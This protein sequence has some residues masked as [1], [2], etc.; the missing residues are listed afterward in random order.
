MLDAL[1]KPIAVLLLQLGSPDDAGVTAVRR[2]LR[3]FLSDPRVI[4]LPRW[5]WY[6]ILYGIVLQRRPAQSAA[7]YQLIWDKEKGFPLKYYTQR[8]AEELQKRLGD[9]FL[10]RYAMRYG[11]P[12][13]APVVAE[14]CAQ[15]VEKLI[16][17]PLYPQY[18]ATTTASALD[19]L[20]QILMRQRAVPAL[21]VVPPFYQHPAYVS[22]ECQVIRETLATLPQ[23]PEK[24]IFSFH[25]IP[26]R[27]ADA[28]DP[29]PQHVETT[30]S[31]LAAECGFLPGQYT[32]AYQSRFGREEWLKP[33]TDE[34]L[35]QMARQG[36]KRVLVITPGFVT[37]CLETIDEI[38]R[39]ARHI[40]QQA[41]GQELYRCHCLNDHPVWIEA[42]QRIVLEESAGC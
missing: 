14:L 35:L 42:L 3:E 39:E 1:R 25:G 27:Y 34:L 13:I 21:R 16:A 26:Q 23:P 8:Q 4:E 9:H 15:Q 2:Y 17:V 29:Y 10:V 31:R 19:A 30:V 37:D 11:T 36:V 41:G 18:S 32:L 7:K 28:G 12:A 5:K 6:P 24:V 38:G 40:F 20:F 22:A 33:Y